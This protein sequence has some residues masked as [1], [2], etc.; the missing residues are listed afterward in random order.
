MMDLNKLVDS[1]I[2]EIKDGIPRIVLSEFK[3]LSYVE[4]EAVLTIIKA[5]YGN[6]IFLRDEIDGKIDYK[7]FDNT[8]FR[9]AVESWHY[10]PMMAKHTQHLSLIHI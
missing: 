9:E 8:A 1:S 7:G 4:R 5:K 3:K 6:L 10:S 2:R